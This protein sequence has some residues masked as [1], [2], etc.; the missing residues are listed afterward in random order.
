MFVYR[1]KSGSYYY[2][3]QVNSELRL[4]K[5][6]RYLSQM[7]SFSE[8]ESNYIVAQ[9]D[10]LEESSSKMDSVVYKLVGKTVPLKDSEIKLI[11]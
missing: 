7:H 5:I 8:Y 1:A 2:A 3:V 4:H 10:E 6:L 9:P 11:V